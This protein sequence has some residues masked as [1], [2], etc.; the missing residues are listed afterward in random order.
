MVRTILVGV[1]FVSAVL[2]AEPAADA[3]RKATLAKAAAILA[4]TQAAEKEKN[5]DQV[6]TRFAGFVSTLQGVAGQFPRVKAEEAAQPKAFEKVTLNA[7]GQKLDAIR[8]QVPAGKGNFDLNWEFVHPKG[9]GMTSWGIIAREGQVD[10]FKTFASKANFAEK[11]VDLPKEN[12]QVSQK[13]TGGKLKAEAEYVLW[14]AF[15]GDKPADVFVRLA[16]TPAK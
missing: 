7:D 15:D 5:A 6:K 1:L 11:G 3:N 13:L 9:S 4:E 14:F 10:G 8:F 16:V 2:A 12:K